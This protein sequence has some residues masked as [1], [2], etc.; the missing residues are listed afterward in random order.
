MRKREGR[1]RRIASAGAT[2]AT[3]N[4]LG[5]LLCAS[6]WLRSRADVMVK[7][8]PSDL[9]ILRRDLVEQAHGQRSLEVVPAFKARAHRQ[10]PPRTYCRSQLLFRVRLPQISGGL[11]TIRF[12]RSLPRDGCLDRSNPT[13]SLAG[14]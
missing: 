3:V 11:L 13:S 12:S 2:C 14:R 10:Q 8:L 1:T 6:W 7:G 4:S 5:A 9:H